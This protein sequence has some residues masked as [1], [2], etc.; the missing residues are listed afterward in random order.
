MNIYLYLSKTIDMYI[1]TQ[2]VRSLDMER[3]VEIKRDRGR[4]KKIICRVD[5]AAGK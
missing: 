3:K 4:S 2:D 5:K 1:K